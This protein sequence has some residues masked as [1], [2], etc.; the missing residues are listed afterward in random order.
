[1]NIEEYLKELDDR[2]IGLWV[3]RQY[4]TP[5]EYCVTIIYNDLHWDTRGCETPTVALDEAVKL[6]GKLKNEE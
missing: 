4:N 3:Y 6:L 2:F 5:L 1:M